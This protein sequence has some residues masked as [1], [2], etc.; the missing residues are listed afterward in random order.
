M[1]AMMKWFRRPPKIDTA[2]GIKVDAMGELAVMEIGRQILDI[3]NCRASDRVKVAALDC[4]KTKLS[5]P[6]TIS[7]CNVKF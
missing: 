5:A 2:I 4:L 6:L 3:C 1:E 7:G